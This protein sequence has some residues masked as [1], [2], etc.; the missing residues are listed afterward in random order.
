MKERRYDTTVQLEPKQVIGAFLSTPR[1]G[2]R[3]K[4]TTVRFLKE[5]TIPGYQLHAVTFEDETGQHHY[6][7]F[8]LGQDTT[9]TWHVSGAGWG[10][11]VPVRNQP[12]ANLGGGG[13]GNVF[14]AGG[15]V[16][17]NGLGVTLAR[18][19][20][21]NGVVLE[22]TVENG[23]ILFLTNQNVEMPVQVELYNGASE[24]VGSHRALPESGLP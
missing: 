4:V 1:D 21:N 3:V 22:D 19:I 7:D 16:S 18:L 13:D 12:W 17:D 10:E 20:S 2:M 23:M 9:V 6:G 8:F 14:Y 11:N 5:R 24:L 15:Y